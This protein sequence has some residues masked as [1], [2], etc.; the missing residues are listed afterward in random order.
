MTTFLNRR[1]PNSRIE[2]TWRLTRKHPRNPSGGFGLNAD[3]QSAGTWKNLRGVITEIKRSQ[4]LALKN[5]VN[6]HTDQK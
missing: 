2:C 6:C 1:R 3:A 4:K 5:A